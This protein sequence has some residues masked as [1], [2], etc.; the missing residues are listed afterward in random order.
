MEKAVPAEYLAHWSK[1]YSQPNP[2]KASKHYSVVVF[3][4]GLEWFALPAL[5][6]QSIENRSSIHSIPRYTNRLLLGMVN[7]RGT[8]QLCFSIE[9][10]LHVALDRCESGANIAVYKRLLV[11]AYNQ[12]NYVFPVDEVGGIERIDDARLENP[13]ATLT[14]RQAEFLKGVIKTEKKRIA[15]LDSTRLFP[16]LEDAIGG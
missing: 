14:Q 16:A 2:A 4:L 7:I 10:L 6:C 12:Q 15:L 3:R 9:R 11:L 13:P 1:A 5:H 8:L